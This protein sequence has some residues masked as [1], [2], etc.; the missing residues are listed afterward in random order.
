MCA[1]SHPST[2]EET[3]TYSH[4]ITGPKAV[5]ER[6]RVNKFYLIAVQH[7]GVTAIL[8]YDKQLGAIFWIMHIL[9]YDMQVGDMLLT[10]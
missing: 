4:E 3:K 2:D 10:H 8:N 5:L 1:C 6:T 9:N 7:G